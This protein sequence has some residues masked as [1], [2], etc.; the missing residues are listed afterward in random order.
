[1]ACAHTGTITN[2]ESLQAII[3][4]VRGEIVQIICHMVIKHILKKYIEIIIQKHSICLVLQEIIIISSIN[5][6]ICKKR[7]VDGLCNMYNFLSLIF[8]FEI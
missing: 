7:A 5:T 6:V 8:I 4:H 1:M 2:M 3:Q